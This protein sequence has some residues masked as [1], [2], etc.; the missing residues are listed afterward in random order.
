MSEIESVLS[1]NRS[2]PPSPEFA[3]ASRLGSEEEYQRLYRESIEDPEGFFG[4]VAQELPWI[5]PFGKVLDWSGA[6]VARWFEG[7]KLNASQVC[8][9]QHAASE[10][11]SQTAIL[12]EGEPGDVREFTYAQRSRSWPSPCSPARESARSTRW[13]SA[14]SR[15]ARC[16]TASKTAGAPP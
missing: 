11:A 6:P 12:W 1:E 10:R 8:V 4:R 14:D 15:P 7:G 2:F 16:A 9:D 13:S 5:E 3:A